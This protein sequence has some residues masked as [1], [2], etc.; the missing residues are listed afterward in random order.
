MG[1]SICSSYR[2]IRCKTDCHNNHALKRILDTD[3]Q[4]SSRMTVLFQTTDSIEE[5]IL[6]H[7]SRTGI[8][9]AGVGVDLCQQNG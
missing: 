5:H 3:Q 4:Y 6:L 2:A 9:K 8:S 7:H 1:D